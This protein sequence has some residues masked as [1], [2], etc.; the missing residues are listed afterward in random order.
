MVCGEFVGDSRKVGDDT[1]TLD[2]YKGRRDRP[3]L[4]VI[5]RS[6]DV[7]G[8]EFGSGPVEKTVTSNLS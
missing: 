6:P 2:T 1:V 3:H 4:T 7:D 5:E 8:R